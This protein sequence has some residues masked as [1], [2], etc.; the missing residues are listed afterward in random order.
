M[1][2]AL[3]QVVADLAGHGPSKHHID[4]VLVDQRALAQRR[5]FAVGGEADLQDRRARRGRVYMCVNSF[6][7]RF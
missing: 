5:Q 3:Q 7:R 1:G 4:C 2:I 6:G